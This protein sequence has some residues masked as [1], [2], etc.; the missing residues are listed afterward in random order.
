M[1]CY[2]FG[3]SSAE[4]TGLFPLTVHWSVGWIFE[5]WIVLVRSKRGGYD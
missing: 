2:S 5:F 4:R 1:I 3:A